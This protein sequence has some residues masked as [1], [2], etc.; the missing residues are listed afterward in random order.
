MMVKPLPGLPYYLVTYY[1]KRGEYLFIIH[2][3]AFVF[4]CES[5]I[6]LFVSLFSYCLMMSN[7]RL[8]KLYF[9]PGVLYWLKPSLDKKE[10]YIKN[11]VQWMATV[12]LVFLFACFLSLRYYYF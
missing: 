5:I 7:K 2:I 3:L 4:V 9:I 8:Y 11:S 1:E 12:F 10:Y 6:L